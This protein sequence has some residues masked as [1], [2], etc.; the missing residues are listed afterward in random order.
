MEKSAV[1]AIL[2]GLSTITGLT[3]TIANASED[4]NLRSGL[5]GGD[6]HDYLQADY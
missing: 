1:L 5:I 3:Y 2:A 4:K 6:D